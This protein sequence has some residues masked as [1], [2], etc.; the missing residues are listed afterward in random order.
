MS[1][2]AFFRSVNIFT[3]RSFD[4]AGRKLRD[5]LRSG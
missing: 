2:L 5:R 4:C 3:R 1:N